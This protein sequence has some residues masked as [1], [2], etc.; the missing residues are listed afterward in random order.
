[1]ASAELG[2]GVALPMVE[3]MIVGGHDSGEVLVLTVN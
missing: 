2:E 1:V 3:E